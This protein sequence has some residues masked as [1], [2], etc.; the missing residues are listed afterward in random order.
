M[1]LLPSIFSWHIAK[2]WDG[3][4]H[5]ILGRT[6][7]VEQT[8]GKLWEDGLYLPDSVQQILEDAP[9]DGSS[10]LMWGK[11]VCIDYVHLCFWYARV[12]HWNN[13]FLSLWR[14]RQDTLGSGMQWRYVGV[15]AKFDWLD[16]VS[17]GCRGSLVVFLLVFLVKGG[18]E[19]VSH[20]LE[21]GGTGQGFHIGGTP[22]SKHLSCFGV[23]DEECWCKG[24]SWLDSFVG[25]DKCEF[26]SELSVHEMDGDCSFWLTHP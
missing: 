6:R 19:F 15:C 8:D 3:C 9:N 4:R 25:M 26:L 22:R 16:E 10:V 14:R 20:V 2:G 17:H 12:C 23:D 1:R 5:G 18:D 21:E 7:R 24:F 13:I 11:C